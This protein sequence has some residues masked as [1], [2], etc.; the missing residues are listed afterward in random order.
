MSGGLGLF[1]EEDMKTMGCVPDGRG[2]YRK[3]TDREKQLSLMPKGKKVVYQENMEEIDTS[4][5]IF[6]PGDVM[7]KKNSKRIITNPKTQRPM[8]ISS[9]QTLAYERATRN[10]WINLRGEFLQQ[11][12]GKPLPLQIEF[13][14]VFS[15]KRSRDYGNLAQL[16]LDLMQEHLWIHDDDMDNVL[17]SYRP[18]S[19]DRFNP[20]LYIRIIN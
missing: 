13:H 15:G 9:E 18:Y 17:P 8:I 2:N 20:G 16:P 4:C 19:I 3:M 1:T 6:I 14:F 11:I 12:K 5:K 7:S 10:F